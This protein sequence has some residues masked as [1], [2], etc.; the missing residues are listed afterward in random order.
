MASPLRVQDHD[1]SAQALAVQGMVAG[2]AVVTLDGVL[3]V[4]YLSPGDRV[5]TRSGAARIQRV[6]VTVIRHA[7]VVRIGPDALGVSRPDDCVT[8]TAAQGLLIRDWRAKALFGAAQAVVPAARLVDGQHIRAEIMAE[9][10]LY[11]LVFE[12]PTVIHA[13]GLE[14]ACEGITVRA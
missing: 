3:P 2:T 8:V 5:V 13:G 11:T 1:S 7:R 4:E 14:M 6:E 12:A 9:A 10:R